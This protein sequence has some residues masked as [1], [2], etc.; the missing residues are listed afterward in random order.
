MRNAPSPIGGI[1]GPLQRRDILAICV[2]LNRNSA[3]KS[4][5]ACVSQPDSL[6]EKLAA[7][8]RMQ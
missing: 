8:A 7:A 1:T 5:D 6:L 2:F 3:P 4:V